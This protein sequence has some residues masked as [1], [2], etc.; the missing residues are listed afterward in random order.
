M[1]A[2]AAFQY[3]Q[4]LTEQLHRQERRRKAAQVVA[5]YGERHELPSEDV[6]EIL[7]ALGL[8]AR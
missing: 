7:A 5:E 8:T 2:L 4:Q 6:T 1:D 3:E